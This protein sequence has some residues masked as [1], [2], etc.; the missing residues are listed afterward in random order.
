MPLIGSCW[1]YPCCS[2]AFFF[3][4]WGLTLTNHKTGRANHGSEPLIRHWTDNVL[5]LELHDASPWL[6]SVRL[7]LSRPSILLGCLMSQ[8]SLP[9]QPFYPTYLC[10]FFSLKLEAKAHLLNK[11]NNFTL[12]PCFPFHYACCLEKTDEQSHCPSF[13][14]LSW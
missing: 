12:K 3:G 9:C 2:E 4:S 5:Q 1:D 10:A 8:Q 7:A 13:P 11:S 6:F 14:S